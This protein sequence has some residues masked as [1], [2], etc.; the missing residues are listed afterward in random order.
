MRINTKKL[1]AKLFTAHWS[2]EQDIFL[3]EHNQLPIEQL[4]QQLKFSEE[5]IIARRK[6]LGLITRTK[7][8]RKLRG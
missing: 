5:E 2:K 8:L 6:V 4:S 7:Q 3:I 1:S